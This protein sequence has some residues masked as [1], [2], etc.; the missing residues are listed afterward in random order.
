MKKIL[1]LALLL[2]GSASAITIVSSDGQEVELAG[3]LAQLSGVMAQ[4]LEAMGEPDKPIRLVLSKEAKISGDT[5]KLLKSA[6]VDLEAAQRNAT[7]ETRK[8]YIITKITFE[9]GERVSQLIDML[10]AANYL[11]VELVME[12]AA[13]R[14]AHRVYNVTVTDE[15][16]KQHLPGELLEMV[17]KHYA[18]AYPTKRQRFDRTP[19]LSLDD[20]LEYQR[21][22]TMPTVDGQIRLSMRHLTNL[23]G[24]ERLAKTYP[25]L[26]ALSLNGNH[27]GSLPKEIEQL[28][29][30]RVLSLDDNQLTSLPPQIGQLKNLRVLSLNHN[31]LE[32]LPPEIGQLANLQK[33]YL[34]NNKLTSLPLEIG[35]LTH[36]QML[37]LGGNRLGQ[38][39]NIPRMGLLRRVIRRFTGEKTPRLSEVFA[40]MDRLRT[41]NLVGNMLDREIKQD[42][43]RRLPNTYV[44]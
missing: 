12:A 41:L 38:T 3:E 25:R 44:H 21:G 31:K 17:A 32:S 23:R 36:L 40:D 5:L 22:E 4:R 6:M 33:L 43:Q 2:S 37:N 28:K 34:A 1:L 26:R 27:L 9:G 7:P 15:Q 8:Y 14:L 19:N 20:L 16:L 11:D 39:Y 29:N 18:I 24:I 42:I 30:L 13:W 10:L 35:Q